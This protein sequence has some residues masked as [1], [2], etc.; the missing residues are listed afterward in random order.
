MKVTQEILYSEVKV[1]E[2]VLRKALSMVHQGLVE[3]AMV[4]RMEIVVMEVAGEHRQKDLRLG[5]VVMEVAGEHRQKGLRLGLV[6]MEVAGEHRQKDLRLV[7][8]WQLL[9]L[10]AVEE[11]ETWSH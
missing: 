5:L 7:R 3:I 4:L 9:D 1:Q 2:W 11:K 8:G 6:V 10:G